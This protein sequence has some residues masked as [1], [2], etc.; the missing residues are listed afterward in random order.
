MRGQRAVSVTGDKD[1]LNAGPNLQELF[2]QLRA[3]EVIHHHIG[4]QQVNLARVFLCRLERCLAAGGGEHAVAKL[5]EEIDDNGA[6][7]LFVVHQQYGLST[8]VIIQTITFPVSA[9]RRSKR[10]ASIDC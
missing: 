1:D 3:G 6:Q 2:R 7:G 10:P 9:Q 8:A 4:D 5:A